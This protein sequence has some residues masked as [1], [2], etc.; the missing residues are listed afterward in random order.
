MYIIK[1]HRDV[2]YN[3][4][5]FI[6]Q[7]FLIIIKMFASRGLET[8]NLKTIITNYSFFIKCRRIFILLRNIFAK[9]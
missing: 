6:K 4:K 7:K 3:K 2:F 1:L 8:N 5:N 9:N